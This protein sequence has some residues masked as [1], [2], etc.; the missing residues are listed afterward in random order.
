MNDCTALLT[1]STDVLFKKS[2]SVPVVEVR[3]QLNVSEMEAEI[4]QKT[5]NYAPISLNT[6]SVTPYNNAAAS[7]GSSGSDPLFLRLRVRELFLNK[8]EKEKGRKWNF[9]I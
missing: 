2:V 1:T 6:A 8:K 3:R 9:L 7:T 5:A 4:T